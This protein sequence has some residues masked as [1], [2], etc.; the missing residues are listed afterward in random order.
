MT[1]HAKADNPRRL[2]HIASCHFTQEGI[3]TCCK[4]Q[5]PPRI[6]QKYN[7]R[8][9]R[10]IPRDGLYHYRGIHHSS[11]N[12]IRRMRSSKLSTAICL[13]IRRVSNLADAKKQGLVPTIHRYAGR[14]IQLVTSH[15]FL[16][17][18]ISIS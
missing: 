8:R 14:A 9:G 5:D 4:D 16:Y 12:H 18:K 1:S 11:G 7:R 17:H 2:A 15:W 3:I 6:I 13:H 10:G